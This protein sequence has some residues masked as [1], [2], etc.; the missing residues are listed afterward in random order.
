MNP[1]IFSS[2][3][4][5][6]FQIRDP[7]PKTRTTILL[8]FPLAHRKECRGWVGGVWG[9]AGWG[10]DSS[11]LTRVSSP[12]P[13]VF[14]GG[15]LSSPPPRS[16][17]FAHVLSTSLYATGRSTS[18]YLSGNARGFFNTFISKLLS[19]QM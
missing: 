13:A 12:P 4:K 7:Y 11:Y 15:L 5:P 14:Y 2:K 6:R 1:R 9:G 19:H 8:L 3:S 17:Q 18:V 16:T 10:F